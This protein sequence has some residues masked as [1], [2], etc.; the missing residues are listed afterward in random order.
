VPHWSVVRVTRSQPIAKAAGH[1][2]LDRWEGIDGC[3]IV[4]PRV[5]GKLGGDGMNVRTLTLI[6]GCHRAPQTQ[7]LALAWIGPP[8]WPH[9]KAH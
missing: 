2:D 6:G 3:E 8:Y 9:R 7:D 4:D 1:V 5:E